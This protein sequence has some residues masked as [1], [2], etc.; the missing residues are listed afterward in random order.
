MLKSISKMWRSGEEQAAWG[1]GK[2]IQG[3]F[4]H[5]RLEMV[6]SQSC[7]NIKEALGT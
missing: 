2:G 4:G 6:V 3:L 7:R 5:N 1:V